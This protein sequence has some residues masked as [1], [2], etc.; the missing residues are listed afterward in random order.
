ML[1]VNGSPIRLVLTFISR[2]SPRRYRAFSVFSGEGKRVEGLPASCAVCETP[3]RPTVRLFPST[4]AC[5]GDWVLEYDGYLVSTNRHKN[6][7]ETVCV[8]MDPVAIGDGKETENEPVLL[9]MK[10]GDEDKGQEQ[11]AV[12]CA[13]CS[14]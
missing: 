2:T 6:R 13:V 5:P 12:P 11:S 9:P 7:A 14:K 4:P 8:D 3:M 10:R 1:L